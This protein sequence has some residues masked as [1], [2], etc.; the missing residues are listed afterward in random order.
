MI[1]NQGSREDCN[2][3]MLKS[4]DKK[5]SDYEEKNIRD[6]FHCLCTFQADRK[7]MLY[8]KYKKDKDTEGNC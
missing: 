2:Q 3:C 4:Y 7:Y 1:Q 8:L 5:D 6:N